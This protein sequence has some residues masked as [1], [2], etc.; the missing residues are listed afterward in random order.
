MKTGNNIEIT[1]LTV[2]P[3]QACCYIVTGKDAKNNQALVIDPG[4]DGPEIISRLK[5]RNL[6]PVYLINTHGH[7][8]HIGANQE[9]KRAFP[10]IVICV[11]QDDARMLTS[12][13]A[14]LSPELG[15]QFTSP[16]ADKLLKEG[17]TLSINN[18]SLS[19]KVIHLPGHTRGG[20]G[21]LYQPSDKSKPIL[22][23]GDTL[24]A[25]GVGRTD[26]PGGSMKQLLDNIKSKILTLPDDTII[27]PGHGPASTVGDEKMHNQ[28][29][30]GSGWMD[31]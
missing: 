14:N 16:A 3:I 7:I 13:A 25:G 29:L 10:D 17:D 21:L 28:F 4:G 23:T 22:F 27:Y 30:T 18:G 19:L 8:D 24:F 6:D 26:F 15:F 2:G 31:E 12:A 1:L 9:I 11:H 20:I 5:K